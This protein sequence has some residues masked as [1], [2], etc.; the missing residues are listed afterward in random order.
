MPFCSAVHAINAS[1]VTRFGP[2]LQLW[3][4]PIYSWN[5]KYNLRDPI[6]G[7]WGLALGTMSGPKVPY[8]D[9]EQWKI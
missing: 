8:Q 7:P 6:S 9:P 3:M 5:A 2:S 4:E 1:P